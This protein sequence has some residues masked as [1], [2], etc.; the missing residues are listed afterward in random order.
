MIEFIPQFGN[1]LFTIG[2]F[3]IALS[4][5]ISI[6]E[7][8]HYIVGRW[9]GIHAEVFSLGIG[10]VIWSRRDQHG[11]KWQIAALPIGGYVK[12]LGDADAASGKDGEVMDA[13]SGDEQR[14]TMHGAPLWARA[15]TVAAGPVFNFI[16]SIIVFSGISLS[17]GAAIYPHEIATV[18][19]LPSAQLGVKAG[20]KLVAIDGVPYPDID[21][22]SDFAADIPIKPV[23]EYTVLRGGTE[24]TVNGPP[25]FPTR[26]AQVTDNWAADTAGLKVDDVVLSIGGQDVFEFSQM[27][28]LINDSQGKPTLIKFWRDGETMEVRVSAQRRDVPLSN[29][30]FETRYVIGVGNGYFFT[31]SSESLGLFE[32]VKIGGQRTWRI[33]TLSL[34]GTAQMITGN[35]STCNLSGPVGIARV[36]GQMASQGISSFL[37]FVA[38]LST[39]VGLLNLFPIP[40]LD[41]GHLV[42]HAYEAVTGRPPSDKALRILMGVGLAL[43]VTLMIFSL[44]NDF[45]CP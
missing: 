19:G 42:F 9:S 20:D 32:A 7:Y 22:F 13:L 23:L 41:G 8:G 1:L 40:I 43:I 38:L 37:A 31:P 14:R 5:I 15:A 39:A 24:I 10:P 11:T 6:H 16:L 27:I 30:G 45:L 4:I 3:V 35:I 12:F 44:S 33:V 25:M 2:A 17:F 34:S 28:P 29:G 18:H 26:I 21:R 36:S